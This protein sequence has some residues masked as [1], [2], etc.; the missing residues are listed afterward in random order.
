[1]L[2]STQIMCG[3]PGPAE[4][5]FVHPAICTLV[6]ADAVVTFGRNRAAGG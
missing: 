1:M 5:T 2:V 6:A 4:V 3:N